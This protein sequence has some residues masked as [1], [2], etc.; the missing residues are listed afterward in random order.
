MSPAIDVTVPAFS[1]TSTSDQGYL[2]AA[3]S[4]PFLPFGP[5]DEYGCGAPIRVPWAQ[6]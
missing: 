2:V 4:R 5:Y 1:D 6:K 3:W